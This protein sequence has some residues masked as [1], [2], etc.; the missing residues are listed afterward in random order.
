MLSLQR[1]YGNRAVASLARRRLDRLAS[2]HTFAVSHEGQVDSV[3]AF[4]D[5]VPQERE[6]DVDE[7]VLWNF[8]VGS[9]VVRR[10]HKRGLEKAA[11]R[12]AGE[13]AADP[14]LRI[15]VLGYA[16]VTGPVD[17]NEDLARRRAE[18]VRDFLV[19][20]G[21]SEDRIVIDSS[22]SRLPMDEGLTSAGL[23]RNRRVEVSK[24]V[25]T[26]T[27]KE[28]SELG[29]DVDVKVK[30]LDHETSSG[31]NGPKITDGRDVRFKFATQTLH[32]QLRVKSSDPAVE[33]GF[34]QFV[35]S[36]LRMA[37]YNDADA[38]GEVA[39]FH[40]PP[41][42]FLDYEHCLDAFTPCRDV[43]LAK[44]PFSM[45]DA[46]GEPARIARAGKPTEIF[47]ETEPEAVF[48]QFIDIPGRGRGVLT[49]VMW[50]ME[51]DVLL[52]VRKGELLIPGG[53]QR[54]QLAGFV[55]MIVG[56]DP[57]KLSISVV[58]SSS[59]NSNPI[60]DRGSFPDIDRAMSMPS[61]KLRERMMNGV[62]RPTVLAV[63][64]PAGGEFDEQIKKAEEELK[65]AL[66]RL[67][68]LR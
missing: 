60:A 11:A 20:Q 47:F 62:C 38:D 59:V 2:E 32:S 6:Q 61:C 3:Q 15:R 26:R 27:G 8:L 30:T 39:D 7:F 12:W 56:P 24:F 37:G 68:D 31:I 48:P 40:A 4:V 57:K 18:S 66:D 55:K 29:P 34:I 21:I 14:G 65:D 46:P 36:D 51:F 43:R 67:T 13:L 58:S 64:G 53:G 41:S 45:A 19:E 35:T 10:G 54:W 50:K 1:A 16:S 25:A 17:L 52:V 63:G 49:R 5:G 28:L 22:G 33:A 42:A 9:D 23:A 44:L